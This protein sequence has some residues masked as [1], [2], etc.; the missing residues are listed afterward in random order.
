MARTT[1]RKTLS[2][3]QQKEVASLS[4]APGADLDAIAAKFGISKKNIYNYRSRYP[5]NGST[6]GS[7]KATPAKKEQG[8]VSKLQSELALARARIHTLEAYIVD[9]ILETERG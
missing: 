6:N 4:L 2:K 7:K 5:Q 9:N 3:D 8:T 1:R